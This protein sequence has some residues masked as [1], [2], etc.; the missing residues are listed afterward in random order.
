MP[1]SSGAELREVHIPSITQ[2]SDLGLWSGEEG[3]VLAL[4]KGSM[5]VYKTTNSLRSVGGPLYNVI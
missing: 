2:V 1:D 4:F 3:S 5:T